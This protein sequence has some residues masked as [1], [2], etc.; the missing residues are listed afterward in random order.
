[1]SG[2]NSRQPHQRP[3]PK[4]EFG[5]LKEI[6]RAREWGQTNRGEEFCSFACPHS[7]ARD[8]S[9]FGFSKGCAS[10]RGRVP[11]TQLTR[12]GTEAAC[13]FS[14]PNSKGR[15]KLEGRIPKNNHLARFGISGFRFRHLDF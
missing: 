6:R 15:K 7:F 2:C 8:D 4:T 5:R 9:D 12:G 10:A 3:N 13:Q 1:M 14:N 11:K